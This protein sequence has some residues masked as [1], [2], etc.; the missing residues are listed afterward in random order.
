M[1]RGATTQ[2]RTFNYDLTTGRLSSAANPENGTLSYT[3]NTDG[4]V[5][6]QQVQYQYD[7]FQRVTQIRRYPDAGGAEDTC[8][9]VNFTYDV[10]ANDWGRLSSAAWSGASCTRGAWSQSY[11]YTPSGQVTVK[12]QNGGGRNLH[13][14]YAYDTEDRMV[15]VQYPNNGFT[16]TYSFNSMGRPNELTDNQATPRRL[17][18]GRGLQLRRLGHFRAVHPIQHCRRPAAGDCHFAARFPTDSKI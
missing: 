2:A 3:Y 17:G 10:G 8:Q 14:N 13:A 16:L 6:N 5:Q 9:R 15:S 18:Q 12:T 1:A 7:T 4:S 11:S